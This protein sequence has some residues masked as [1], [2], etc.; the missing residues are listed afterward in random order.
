MIQMYFCRSAGREPAAKSQLQ[1]RHSPASGTTVRGESDYTA[2]AG[3]WGT[4]G[5]AA[6]GSNALD[7]AI[8]ESTNWHEQLQ[9]F[10]NFG[11]SGVVR[12]LL[13]IS[14]GTSN[15]LLIGEK[16]QTS[17]ALTGNSCNND[18]GYVDGWDNDM[19]VFS[20]GAS[21]YPGPNN[22]TALAMTHPPT[23]GASW[24]P[25]YWTM[26]SSSDTCGGFFGSIHS[27]GMP[28]LFCD[29]TVHIIPYNISEAV[30]FSL[31]SI[32][33]TDSK[34]RIPENQDDRQRL[35]GYSPSLA[36]LSPRIGDASEDRLILP[37]NPQ[38]A[39]PSNS[40]IHRPSKPD[41]RQFYC[42][43]SGDTFVDNC[44]YCFPQFIAH[45]GAA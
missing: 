32:N 23:P 6:N 10:S 18:Q 40:R 5:S 37:A 25:Q 41:P 11:G 43:W 28:A 19:I 16:Y 24:V 12:T 35:T 7:G 22:A 36:L 30:F 34:S 21:G 38:P 1:S 27:A 26:T 14:D 3:S 29:G 2:N 4:L 33:T 9:G 17:A 15:T 8:V 42:C 31:C 20:Q 39:R 45:L 44:C 13:S